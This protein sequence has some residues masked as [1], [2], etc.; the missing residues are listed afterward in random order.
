MFT[1]I[2]EKGLQTAQPK[3]N[4][5]KFLSLN[6][7]TLVAIFIIFGCYPAIA[8][9]PQSY[10]HDHEFE[11]SVP[12]KT[13]WSMDL[14]AGYRGL[15]Q[16]RFEGDKI[17]GYSNEH[18]EL[19]YFNNYLTR[20]NLVLSLGLRYRFKNLF[21]KSEVDEFR[22]IEQLEIT[23]ETSYL[24]L[25]HRFRV[26]QRF[27]E[28]VIHRLR[29]EFGVSRQLNETLSLQAATE[30]LYAISNNLKPEAE[31]RFSVGLVNS[32]FKDLELDLSFEYRIENYA[33]DLAH[34]FFIV[35]GVNFSP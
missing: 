14:A 11:L 20:E 28:H 9:N 32:S 27:T 21:D 1:G 7:I 19:N 10:F 3:M 22:I 15:L 8:Q 35:T 6:K 5:I 30:A 31:Q 2:K 25:S 24:S 4:F 16:E 29:Y 33:V 12:V 23:S 34:E 18:L 26:E 13:K 17:T